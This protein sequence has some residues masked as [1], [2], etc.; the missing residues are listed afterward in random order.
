[1]VPDRCEIQVDRRLMPGE[2]AGQVLAGLRARL[3]GIPG[4]VEV[5]LLKEG[6]A[7]HT[8]A[9]AELP[10]RFG[11]ALAAA[12][13]AP[14]SEGAAWCSDAGVLAGACRETIVW[15]PGA[16]AQAHTI[17]EYIETAALAAGCE[18]M[19]HYLRAAARG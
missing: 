17:D 3:A 4:G 6:L 10:R 15:G 1:V 13:V 11:A 19:R 12:G 5:A 9:A 16:I 18:T 2:T 7:F 14:A 8:D